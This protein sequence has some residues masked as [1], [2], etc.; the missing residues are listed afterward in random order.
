MSLWRHGIRWL[1]VKYNSNKEQSDDFNPKLYNIYAVI[2]RTECKEILSKI[3]KNNAIP[4]GN[5]DLDKLL[6][7]ICPGDRAP[8]IR[9]LASHPE[10]KNMIANVCRNLCVVPFN[11]PAHLQMETIQCR[12]AFRVNK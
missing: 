5:Y 8:A 11:T 9:L 3:V 10:R 7:Q 12:R 4:S 1:S 2:E 6:S